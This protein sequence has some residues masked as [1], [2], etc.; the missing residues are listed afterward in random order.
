MNSSEAKRLHRQAIKE[1]F[2]FQCVYCGTTHEPN[3]LTIDHV[4]P[5]SFGGHSLTNNLVPSCRKCN[6]A[7]G[8]RNWLQWMRDTFGPTPREQLIHSHIYGS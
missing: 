4:R 1:A 3:E 8:S 5:R 6:Q 2:N 7:K